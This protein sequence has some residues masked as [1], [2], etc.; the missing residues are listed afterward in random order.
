[1]QQA[2]GGNE[3]SPVCIKHL[4]TTAIMKAKLFQNSGLH[5]CLCASPEN[6]YLEKAGH[7]YTSKS[8]SS[9]S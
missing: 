4:A 6:N 5:R 9:Y 3:T 7:T 1:M 8:L 2:T